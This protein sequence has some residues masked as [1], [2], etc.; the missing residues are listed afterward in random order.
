M[1]QA[2]GCQLED[3]LWRRRGLAVEAEGFASL[4][5]EPGQHLDLDAGQPAAGDNPLP[6][7]PADQHAG[8]AG[9]LLKHHENPRSCRLAKPAELRKAQADRGDGIRGMCSREVKRSSALG[10]NVVQGCH[11][12]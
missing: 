6:A 4:L 12:L 7:V 10:Q 9:D 5:A 11:T 1:W 8:S 2:D 3:A